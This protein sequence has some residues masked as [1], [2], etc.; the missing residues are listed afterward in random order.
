LIL[1]ILALATPFLPGQLAFLVLGLLILIFGLLQNF[2]GFALRDADA[3]GSWF[4]R[5]GGS[6]LTGL[7]LMAMPSLT[8]AGLAI[9]LGL[10]WF[11]SGASEAGEAIRHRDQTDWHWSLADGLVSIL[12]GLAI[13]IQWPISGIMSIGLFVG[14]RCISVGWSGLVGSPQITAPTATKAQGLHPDT[15]LGLAPHPYVEKLRNQLEVEQAI[16]GRSDRGWRWLF[17]LTFFAIHA[18]R[19]N[20]DWNLVGLLSPAGAVAGDVA[21]AILLAY[22]IVA[23]LSVSW[24]KLTRPLER[25]AWTSYL[26][27]LDQ[28]QPAGFRT[29]VR[30]W[31]LT[32]RMRAA[33]RRGQATGSPTAA[34]G[35]GIQ[36]GLPAVA[37]LI[38]L[39]PLW[40]V[41]WF[42]D[43]ETWVTGAWEIWAEQ[44]RHLAREHGRGGQTPARRRRGRSGFLSRIPRRSR[45]RR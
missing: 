31:W 13:A 5:G 26:A 37:I 3:E 40:G 2:A 27:A 25:R 19:M 17:L 1:G 22:G 33:V 16:R 30:R 8:F 18:A 44:H 14:L 9:L 11:V 41:S 12:L 7:L 32:R 20:I 15:R 10:S 34:L 38:A 36:T 6:I 23:P 39:T 35:W 28:N 21:L 29:R 45:R 43:S 42:F 24:R 4:S